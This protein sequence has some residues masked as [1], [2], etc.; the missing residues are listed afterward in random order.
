MCAFNFSSPAAGTPTAPLRRPRRG[1]SRSRRCPGGRGGAASSACR[2]RHCFLCLFVFFFDEDKKFKRG[3]IEN[4][5]TTSARKT[6]LLSFFVVLF[7]L[8]ERS[9]LW[10]GRRHD[11]D[12]NAVLGEQ[13]HG[14][15]KTRAT[16]AKI[17]CRIE[18]QRRRRRRR[19]KNDT[20]LAVYKRKNDCRRPRLVYARKCFEIQHPTTAMGTRDVL[21]G[22]RTKNTHASGPISNEKKRTINDKKRTR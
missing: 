5:P 12:D 20:H 13:S 19:K 4:R 21:L 16:K 15:T 8:F 14:E 18:Q 1:P 6:T 11:N 22:S 10:R 17:Q 7:Y 3:E 2:G 9:L